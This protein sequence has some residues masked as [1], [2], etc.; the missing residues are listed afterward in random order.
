M[1]KN[2]ELDNKYWREYKEK[3]SM[4]GITLDDK[5]SEEDFVIYGDRLAQRQIE[6][7]EANTDKAIKDSN[8]IDIGCGLGRVCRPYSKQFK[9]VVGL[10]INEKILEAAKAYC[11]GRENIEFV[12]NDGV[13][14]P[15]EDNHFDFVYSG[16]VLQHIPRIDVI[17]NY[18]R[19]GLRVLKPG[20]LLNFS[21]QV[22]MILRKGGVQGDRVGAQVRAT[23]IEEILNEMGHE[24]VA[25]YYDD[26]D[27]VPHFNIVIK[28]LE[29]DEAK[30]NI[31]ARKSSPYKID[32]KMIEIR[33]VRTGIFEDLPSYTE[34]RKIWSQKHAKQIT[35]FDH[36]PLVTAKYLAKAL[37]NKISR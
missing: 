6:M 36:S 21:V 8:V 22:W 17:T 32:P 3:T 35:F 9:Q 11:Q 15:F 23:D 10:D 13:S 25:I 24:L 30:K 20:G 12:Q 37:K 14:I 1:V 4:A 34:F 33:Q 31:E 2:E 7:F 16:G 29:E 5:I 19:E 27:P 26:I 28:K 18:F